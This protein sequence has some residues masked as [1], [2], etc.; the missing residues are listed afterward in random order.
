MEVYR[1]V[2]AEDVQAIEREMKRLRRFS[3]VMM[4]GPFME[5]LGFG[6]RESHM[7]AME[8]PRMLEHMLMRTLE[9]RKVHSPARRKSPKSR[10]EPEA[11]E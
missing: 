7:F 4:R 10:Q 2:K 6:S 5:E 3:E 9:M 8:F 11:S 1:A